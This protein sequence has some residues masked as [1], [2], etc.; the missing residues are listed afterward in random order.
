[1]IQ[2]PLRAQSYETSSLTRAHCLALHS[3]S[4]NT[5][6]NISMW[7][8]GGACSGSS[9]VGGSLVPVHRGPS[10]STAGAI[11]VEFGGVPVSIDSACNVARRSAMAMKRASRFDAT[12]FAL[13]GELDAFADDATGVTFDEEEESL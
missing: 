5:E 7:S 1:M 2:G 9:G 10:A 11:I 6:S 4:S 3:C 12:A 8:L 13:T